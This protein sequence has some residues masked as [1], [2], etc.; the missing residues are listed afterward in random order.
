MKL[1]N[2]IRKFFG[3]IGITLLAIVVLGI[4]FLTTFLSSDMGQQFIKSQ[5]QSEFSNDVSWERAEFH[6]FGPQTIKGL[7]VKNFLTADEVTLDRPLYTLIFGFREVAS[8]S[9]KNLNLQLKAPAIQLENVN[10]KIEIQKGA[11]F[12]A[13]FIGQTQFEGQRG[14]FLADL[15]LFIND[16]LQID[17]SKPHS[18]NVKANHFPVLIFD[19][20]F[21]LD[22]NATKWIGNTINID[23]QQQASNEDEILCALTADSRNLNAKLEFAIHPDAITL[24]KEGVVN[25]TIEPQAKDRVK[26]LSQTRGSLNLQ[27]FSMPLSPEI[28]WKKAF[29]EANV[30]I[31]PAS[32]Q[33]GDRKVACKETYGHYLLDNGHSILQLTGDV[34][35]QEEYSPWALNASFDPY[36]HLNRV[37]ITHDKEII[38]LLGENVELTMT[39]SKGNLYNLSLQTSNIQMPSG[40][41]SLEDQTFFSSRVTFTSPEIVLNSP[42]VQ[43]DEERGELY[44]PSITFEPG[45]PPLR[46]IQGAF[47]FDFEN[48]SISNPYFTLLAKESRYE[49]SWKNLP[50]NIL[51]SLLSL[52]EEECRKVLFSLG[53]TTQGDFQLNAIGEIKGSLQGQL[54]HCRLN[55]KIEHGYLKFIDPFIIETTATPQLGQYVLSDFFVLFKGLRSSSERIRLTLSPQDFFA[56]I[57]PFAIENTQIGKGS[58]TLG[59]MV[60]NRTTELQAVLKLLLKNVPDTIDI[61]MTPLYFSLIDSKLT[62]QRTDMLVLNKYPMAFWGTIDLKNN[63][64]QMTLGISAAALESIIGVDFGAG[65]TMLTVPIT[66]SMDGARVSTTVAARKIATLI[67]STKTGPVGVAVGMALDV[68]SGALG[69]K[70]PPPPT[71]SPLPWQSEIPQE[72]K[73]KKSTLKKIEKTVIPLLDK[74]LN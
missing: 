53:E 19:A 33:V 52:N 29:A 46:D 15:S 17:P 62:I 44:I 55:G 21:Q 69:E 27:S 65:D 61:W 67:A 42:Q 58:I 49:A 32:L 4:T 6:F 36:F 34:S 5:L 12:I 72:K 24:S 57:D 73:E 51:C 14:D 23:F 16:N 38:P 63:T 68:L 28:D 37:E 50:V 64:V 54:G 11:P 22:G 7:E 45:T 2:D 25:L 41:L 70:A 66:G 18:V 47:S 48:A 60:F 3:I 1:F 20:Y 26:L 43:W 74:L 30:T 8:L 13:H 39:A 56:P 10:G 59:K 40:T 9:V 35:L 31:Q 71:T